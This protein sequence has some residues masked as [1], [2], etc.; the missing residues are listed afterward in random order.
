MRAN[1]IQGLRELTSREQQALTAGEGVTT[2]S[3]SCDACSCDCDNFVNKWPTKAGG[4]AGKTTGT[5]ASNNC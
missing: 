4:S 5:K 2:C 1:R 3:C